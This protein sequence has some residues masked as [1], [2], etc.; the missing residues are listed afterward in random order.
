MTVPEII[1]IG[2][3]GPQ[4]TPGT[5]AVDL[6]EAV[7]TLVYRSEDLSDT[8]G[9]A[10]LPSTTI[11]PAN[12]V[13]QITVNASAGTYVLRYG[14]D[15]TP[16]S[17]AIPFDDDGTEI[18]NV[19][20]SYLD[21]LGVV[22]N[23]SVYTSVEV[24]GGPGGPGGVT[25][26][27][28]TFGGPEGSALNLLQ[29]YADGA[30]LLEGYVQVS[31]W[32]TLSP[33]GLTYRSGRIYETDINQSKIQKW[34]EDGNLV[35]E[36][37]SYGSGDNQ[38]IYPLGIDTDPSGNVY[39][40]DTNNHRVMKFQS[41]G[42]QISVWGWA[43]DAVNTN[44]Y[45]VVAS[46]STAGTAGSNVGQLNNPQ[47]I[48]VGLNG[49]VYVVDGSNHR[50][51]K[52]DSDG[53]FLLT[54]GSLGGGDGMF[55]YPTNI[56]IDSTGNVYVA[57]AYNN[58]IQKFDY[59]GNYLAT[60]SDS[61]RRPGYMTFDAADNLYFTDSNNYNIVKL[62]SDL[63]Y[64]TFWGHNSASGAGGF[65]GITG[66]AIDGDDFV[67]VGDQVQGRI[68][69]FEEY[70]GGTP[71]VTTTTL[72]EGQDTDLGLF[73]LPFDVDF[74]A[75]EFLL[76]VD[77]ELGE[78]I[79]TD[80]GNI[81]IM[82]LGREP[83]HEATW[84]GHLRRWSTVGEWMSFTPMSTEY[85]GD[86]SATWDWY[87]ANAGG[88]SSLCFLRDD[89]GQFGF[90]YNHLDNATQQQGFYP[91]NTADA[92]EEYPVGSF[93]VSML[94]GPP[95]LRPGD[96]ARVYVYPWDNVAGYI[97]LQGTCQAD[98]SSSWSG[99]QGS[100]YA[101]IRNEGGV[102]AEELAAWNAVADIGDYV[103]C[104]VT[105]W[106]HGEEGTLFADSDLSDAPISVP[107]HGIS[108]NDVYLTDDNG[109]FYFGG[110]LDVT[111][112]L[113]QLQR[114]ANEKV[115]ST[116]LHGLLGSAFVD[117]WAVTRHSLYHEIDNVNDPRYVIGTNDYAQWRIVNGGTN[118]DNQGR[119]T[120]RKVYNP[121]DTYTHRPSVHPNQMPTGAVS[122]Y[123]GGGYSTTLTAGDI[124]EFSVNLQYSQNSQ[125]FIQAYYYLQP[126]SG[127]ENQVQIVVDGK[128]YPYDSNTF[129]ARGTYTDELEYFETAYPASYFAGSQTGRHWVG[130]KTLNGLPFWL[131]GF[132]MWAYS[133]NPTIYE[134]E[135]YN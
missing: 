134:T 62:D 24:T 99:T 50:V 121:V 45:V 116:Q 66:I 25:P 103:H 104:Y 117:A 69:K 109:Y 11:N 18:I 107:Q 122:M 127:I 87:A 84:I 41:D 108:A 132:E 37:G 55:T 82:L 28:I 76:P 3:M 29:I 46:G 106:K 113:H 79:G 8:T 22:L 101:V 4:G 129:S 14:I 58:R 88:K 60:Y 133:P 128:P 125:Y 2:L 47:D 111:G 94:I 73:K 110:P 65:Q 120:E 115:S 119:P 81:R 70:T 74:Y 31:E 21:E 102:P 36:W 39:I 135:M 32:S 57:D 5:D 118:L 71:T 43:V 48:A 15:G 42:T 16:S 80:Q 61:P 98:T 7:T 96:Y 75:N 93:E 53:A 38:M 86:G 95:T 130:F 90:Y 17:L 114:Q 30:G 26:Y 49:D 92:D 97:T 20:S 10:P 91:Y 131:A 64:L 89:A 44:D 40:A 35:I 51:N 9:F 59:D 105:F 52:Y 72:V 12:E 19:L 124:L 100:A 13:Q 56:A 83:G 123:S 77:T 54:W 6:I 33:R 27:L 126:G 67:Y 85:N 1:E 112:V 23:G 68:Q 78:A 63:N 34:D